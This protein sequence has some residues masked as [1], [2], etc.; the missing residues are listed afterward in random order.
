VQLPCDKQE[1]T[2]Y[3]RIDHRQQAEIHPSS[4]VNN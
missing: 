3:S 1:N 2:L 4:W